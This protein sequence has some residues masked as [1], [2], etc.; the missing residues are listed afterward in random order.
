M[1]VIA[2]P[3]DPHEPT[4]TELASDAAQTLS[5]ERQAIRGHAHVE[6]RSKPRPGSLMDLLSR[7]DRLTR[8]P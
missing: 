2:R 1:S 4:N 3:S 8:L 6:K 7:L 5:K